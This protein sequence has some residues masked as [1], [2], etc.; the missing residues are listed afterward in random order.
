MASA[1][2]SY[3]AIAPNEAVLADGANARFFNGVSSFVHLEGLPGSE[4]FATLGAFVFLHVAVRIVVPVEIFPAGERFWAELARQRRLLQV[5]EAH[6]LVQ[7]GLPVE[8]LLAMVTLEAILAGVVEHVRPKLGRLDELFV[9]HCALVRFFTC[10]SFPMSIQRLFSCKC[11]RTLRAA[12]RTFAGVRSTMFPQGPS[13]WKGFGAQIT[14]EW[15]LPSMS[16]DVNVEQRR[17]IERLLTVRTLI[18]SFP[19]GFTHMVAKMLS[20]IV[21]SGEFLAAHFARKQIL[22]NFPAAGMVQV[23]LEVVLPGEIFSALET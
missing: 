18:V 2:V 22:G 9:A 14:R 15:F 12:V 4:H 21:Q 23:T 19:L 16:T 11:G 20:Q 5:H 13:G 17:P 6:M 7:T 3:E 1:N 10:V 8:S